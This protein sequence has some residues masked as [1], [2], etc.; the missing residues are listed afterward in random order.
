MAAARLSDRDLL[1]STERAAAEE[2]RTTAELIALLAEVDSRKLYRGEGYP[3]LFMYCRHHLHLSE[4]SAYSRITAA[5]AAR[6]FPI[7]LD[8]L[9]EGAITLT[10]IGLLSAHLTDE[11]HEALVDAVQHLSKRDVERLVAMLYGQPDIPASIRRLPESVSGT[12]PALAAA[13]VATDAGAGSGMLA[14]AEALTGARL[15]SDPAVMSGP[16]A[17]AE[18]TPAEAARPTGSTPQPL[19][20]PQTRRDAVAPLAVGR[21]LL[22]VTIGAETHARLD[23]AR[24]LLRHVVPNGDLAL[25]LDRALALLVDQLE[26][27]KTGRRSRPARARVASTPA[28][29]GRPPGDPPS[30]RYI[31]ASVR[32]EV[33][34]RDAGRCAFVGPHGRCP[35]TGFLEYHHV[36]PFARG[37]A[38]DAANIELRCR[39]HNAYEAEQQFGER[40]RRAGPGG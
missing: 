23:R 22:R 32:R 13:P 3:S 24:D 12:S 31:R 17:S 1:D 30:G 36:V 11:N 6:R 15:D 38:S 9:A 25:I 34:A 16:F 2:R 28:T 33:W 4:F 5:R 19:P 20:G 40:A 27:R 39:A 37:G 18:S 7:L 14:Q 26:G 35:E 29:G 21:Y 10:S 8:R